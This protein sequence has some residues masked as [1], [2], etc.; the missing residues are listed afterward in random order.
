MTTNANSFFILGSPPVEIPVKVRP[1]AQSIKTPVRQQFG[2]WASYSKGRPRTPLGRSVSLTTGTLIP[3]DSG[4]EH[5][6]PNNG[7]HPQAQESCSPRVGLLDP[8]GGDVG[9]EN[10]TFNERIIGATF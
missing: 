5:C 1:T 2:R 4:S 6:E 10:I 3:T 7:C 8:H 9:Q